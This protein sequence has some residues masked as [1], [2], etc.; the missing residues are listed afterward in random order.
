MPTN[1]APRRGRGTKFGK[2]L[3][4][5][6]AVYFTEEHLH[7]LQQKLGGKDAGAF[8]R[9]VA[10]EALYNPESSENGDAISLP[11][12]ASVPCGP[13]EEA[14]VDN[15]SRM[16]VNG[17]W[18][19][20]LGVTD[21]D[22]FMRAYGQSMEGAHITDG[23]LLLMARLPPHKKPREGQPTLVQVIKDGEA[24]GTLKSWHM[25][26]GKPFLR[27]GDG[28]EFK[29]DSRMEPQPIGTVKRAILEF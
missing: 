13:L 20:E 27:D 11:I 1:T 22:F 2:P 18:K 5:R 24:F 14:F 25:K 4:E 23:A 6:I 10:L 3:S 15:P 12:L 16:I 21:S 8:I 17:D 26:N 19:D 28:K 7:D 9:D 29:V